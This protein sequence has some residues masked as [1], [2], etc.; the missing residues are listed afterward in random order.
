M[1]GVASL[2]LIPGARGIQSAGRE[3]SSGRAADTASWVSACAGLSGKQVAPSPLVQGA[4]PQTLARRA[5]RLQ[6]ER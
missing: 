4:P 1:V 6:P 5:S 3:G 2:P